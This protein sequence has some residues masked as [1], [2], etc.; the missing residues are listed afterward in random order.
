[1]ESRHFENGVDFAI[2]LDKTD[3]LRKFR[4][5]FYLKDGTINMCGNSLGL[6]CKDAEEA[7]LKA[8]N[9]WKEEGI[10]FWNYE[11]NKYFVYS[12]ELAAVMASFIGADADEVVVAGCTTT[13]I[14]QGISTLYKPTKERYKILIDNLNFPTDRYAVEGQVRL[15]GYDPKDAVKVVESKDGK[16]IS[17]DAIIEAM[18]HDV[19]LIILSTVLYRSSQILDMQKITAAAKERNILIGWDFCHAIGAIEIDMKKIDADFAVWCTYKYLNGGP[20]STAALYLNRKHFEKLPGLPGW[21]G[22]KIETQFLM[23]QEFD[24]ER[25]ARGWQIGSPTIFSMAS[26][27]GALRVIK[28]AGIPQIRRKSL[29]LT[30]YLMYLTEQK[31]AAYDFVIGNPKD[32]DKRGGHVCLEHEEAFRISQMLKQHGVMPDFREP[33]IIRITPTA[34]YT[35]YQEIYK[36]VDIIVDIVKFEKY[37]AISNQKGK[38]T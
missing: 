26:L 7:L 25:N 3:P 21:F 12:S 27:E 31:L 1:M 24:H 13:M 22:N 5:R 10:K 17:E 4:N 9:I 2:T 32:D 28:E 6:A 33:N 20:G 23:R 37:K 11:N 16:Y 15:K 30:A 8:L 19:A 35:S 36:V 14:H 34:L 29:Q 38:V 18:T